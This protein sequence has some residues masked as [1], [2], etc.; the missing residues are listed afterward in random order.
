MFVYI[1]LNVCNALVL[2]IEW[3]CN[4][5]FFFDVFSVRYSAKVLAEMAVM[6]I[7]LFLII[8]IVVQITD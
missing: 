2:C 1:L 3:Y 4:D 5:N 7:I 6:D 8:V